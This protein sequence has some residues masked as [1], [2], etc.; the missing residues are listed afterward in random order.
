[1]GWK[2]YMNSFKADNE[3]TD[4]LSVESTKAPN[5]RAKSGKWDSGLPPLE[6]SSAD[7]KQQNKGRN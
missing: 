5:A 7:I 1:M 2:D 3:D 6:G 4:G